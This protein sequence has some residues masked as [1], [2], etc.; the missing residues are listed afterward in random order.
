MTGCISSSCGLACIACHGHSDPFRLS[1]RSTL[2]TPVGSKN[3]IGDPQ[4]LGHWA[5]VHDIHGRSVGPKSP[6]DDLTPWHECPQG[7]FRESKN[8]HHHHPRLQA[9]METKKKQVF[10]KHFEKMN[11]TSSQPQFCSAQRHL[12]NL[13][14]FLPRQSHG[15]CSCFGCTFGV[16]AP[17]VEILQGWWDAKNAQ[18]PESNWDQICWVAELKIFWNM[19][20]LS[21]DNLR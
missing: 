3:L 20:K 21:E 2:K 7:S 16:A 14:A 8:T 17:V 6:P 11:E 10:Q 5:R 1:N 15:S 19:L 13:P 12:G 18:R 9:R 4:R